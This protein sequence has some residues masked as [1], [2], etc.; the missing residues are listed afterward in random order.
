MS[1]QTLIPAVLAGRCANGAER[2]KGQIVHAV[3][4][5]VDR[6]QY[7]IPAYSLALCGKT[8]G[9]RSAGWGERAGQAITCPRCLKLAGAEST[10]SVKPCGGD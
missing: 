6:A 10:R 4:V 8:H 3:P 7:G 5:R 1:A 9:Q 2:G